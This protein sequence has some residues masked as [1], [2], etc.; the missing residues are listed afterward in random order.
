L[1]VSSAVSIGMIDALAPYSRRALGGRIPFSPSA[2]DTVRAAFTK[3]ECAN[4]TV[5]FT[6]ERPLPDDVLTELVAARM[7]EID[8]D[9]AFSPKTTT[10]DES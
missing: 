3:R 7:R 9:G 8:P 5:R 2:L 4:G 10:I 6:R 1:S